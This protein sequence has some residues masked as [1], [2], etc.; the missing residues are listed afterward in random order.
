MYGITHGLTYAG[1]GKLASLASS[2][3]VSQYGPR[4]KWH[5]V[6]SILRSLK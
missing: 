6:Q 4:L 1:A 3:I 2:K 5:E